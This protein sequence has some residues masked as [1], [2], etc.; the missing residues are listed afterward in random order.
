LKLKQEGFDRVLRADVWV[1]GLDGNGRVNLT[2]NKFSN[3]QPVWGKSGEVF[4]ISNRSKNDI[5]NIWSIRPDASLQ[6][7]HPS[8]WPATVKG[9]EKGAP[10]ASVE[11]NN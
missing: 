1:I 9:S 10:Q 11:T 5:E 7:S 6:R 8:N 4:F 2:N 3:L